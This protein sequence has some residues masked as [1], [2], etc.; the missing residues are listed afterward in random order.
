MTE[1]PITQTGMPLDEFIRRYDIDGPF[2]I[3][4]GEV[5]E[6]APNVAQHVITIRNVRRVLEKYAEKGAGEVFAEATFVLQ[7]RQDWVKGSRQPDVLFYAAARFK[8]YTEA[9]E[10]WQQKPFALVPDLAVEVLSPNDRMT[11]VD[12]KVAL[13]LADGV[14]LVWVVNPA[15]QNVYVYRAGSNTVMIVQGD[16]ALTGGDVLPKF[17]VK[18][19]ALFADLS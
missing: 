4:E 8:R 9:T 15:R 14:R 2:E 17:S 7:D 11:D 18:L 6:L 19:A 5:V 12:R 13:Y 1:Q 16:D 10:N 3:L